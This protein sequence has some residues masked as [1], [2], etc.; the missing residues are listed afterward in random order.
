[1]TEKEPDEAAGDAFRTEAEPAEARG[2]FRR[3]T[4]ESN[5]SARY[6]AI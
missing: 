6:G 1:M 4:D 5:I 2:L 3:R